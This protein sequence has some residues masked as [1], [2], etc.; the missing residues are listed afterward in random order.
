MSIKKNVAPVRYFGEILFF[1][2]FGLTYFGVF[3]VLEVER[4][5]IKQQRL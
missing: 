1:K 3:L 5:L 2:K 4:S